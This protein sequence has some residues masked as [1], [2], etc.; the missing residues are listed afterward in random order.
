[1]K[2]I[3]KRSPTIPPSPPDLITYKTE[4]IHVSIEHTKNLGNYENIKIMVGQ[5]ITVIDGEDPAQIR[6]ELA[7]ELIIFALK[8]GDLVSKNYDHPYST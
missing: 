1:M 6:E 3:R 7:N 2:V 8:Q 4:S 5:T